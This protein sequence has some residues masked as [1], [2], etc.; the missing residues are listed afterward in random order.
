MFHDSSS[1]GFPEAPKLSLWIT[2]VSYRNVEADHN[3]SLSGRLLGSKNLMQ[4]K[5]YEMSRTNLPFNDARFAKASVAEMRNDDLYSFVLVHDGVPL[6]RA[7][8]I[9]R[10][11]VERSEFLFTGDVCSVRSGAAG[12]RRADADSFSVKEHTGSLQT[13]L[14]KYFKEVERLSELQAKVKEIAI[15]TGAKLLMRGILVLLFQSW[16]L[17]NVCCIG[18][19]RPLNLSSRW[20]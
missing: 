4:T 11:G 8:P 5:L 15:R 17:K 3:K 14:L 6:T 16:H 18:L 2:E 9:S 10:S 7:C 1:S 13:H 19:H 12:G 20:N